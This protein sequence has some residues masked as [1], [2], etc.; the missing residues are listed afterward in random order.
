MSIFGNGGK[1][2]FVIFLSDFCINK[3]VFGISWT[4]ES[5]RNSLHSVSCYHLLDCGILARLVTLRDWCKVRLGECSPGANR[6]KVHL[7][8]TG[9]Q[10]PKKPSNLDRY[11]CEQQNSVLKLN[12]DLRTERYTHFYDYSV[13]KKVRVLKMIKISQKHI[14]PRCAKSTFSHLS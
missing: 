11:R 7:S 2:V 9:T 1:Y 3:C 6:K 4:A 5:W 10:N 8:T 12:L 14:S 13:R